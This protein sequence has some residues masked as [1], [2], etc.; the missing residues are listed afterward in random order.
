[1]PWRSFRTAGPAVRRLRQGLVLSYGYTIYNAQ[2]KGTDPPQL[3]TQMVLLRD[4]KQVFTGKVLPYDIGK[5][6][7][8]K[9]LKVN[10]GLRIGP[11]LTPG[12]YVLQVIVTDNLKHKPIVATQTLDFE[13]VE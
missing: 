3:Q 1:M 7:D 2:V 8:M 4:G 6:V 10:G 13:I 5:Q 12:D 11:E 9:R